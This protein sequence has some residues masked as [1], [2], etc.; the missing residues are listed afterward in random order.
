M[1]PEKTEIRLGRA[2]I[3]MV[4][5]LS[6]GGAIGGSFVLEGKLTRGSK[7]RVVRDGVVV[8]E[9][10][11]DSLRRFK[12]DVKEVEKGFE[13]GIGLGNFQD[14]KAK[15]IV[16]VYTEESKARKLEPQA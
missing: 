4:Y 6:K 15:D 3:R 8:H 13:C 9:G 11:L 1:E 7:A 5:K 2:E 14:I 12:D 10:S 16:E